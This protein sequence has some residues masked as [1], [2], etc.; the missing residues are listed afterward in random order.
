MERKYLKLGGR[1]GVFEKMG[2]FRTL[3]VRKHE[4]GNSDVA[5][6]TRVAARFAMLMCSCRG[7]SSSHRWMFD[8]LRN[9]IFGSFVIT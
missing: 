3:K 8:I 7:D 5:K 6:Q 9:I 1:L 2:Q 4:R